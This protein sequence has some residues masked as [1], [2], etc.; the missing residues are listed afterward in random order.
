VSRGLVAERAPL[1]ERWGVLASAVA[2][3]SFLPFAAGVL[4]GRCFYYRDLV[5]AFF[6]LRRFGIEGLLHGEMRFWNAYVHEGEPLS[7]PAISY[8]LDLLQ[9]LVP[10]ERGFS[11]LLALHVPV[12]AVAFL[13]L[14]RRLGLSPLAAAGAALVYSLGGF[15]LSCLN[16]YV[17][18]LAAAWAP[19]VVVGV[20][21]AAE[22]GA[23]RTA[24]GAL[25]TALAISTLGM[26]I[27]LQALLVGLVLAWRPREPGRVV[28][29]AGM[30]AL[31]C[32]L[33]APL[34]L[35]LR[36]VVPQGGRAG[37]MPVDVVLAYSVHPLSLLQVVVQR[38]FGD[39]S[40]LPGSWWGQNFFPS[41]YPYFQSLYLG[42]TV[43]GVALV[44]ATRPS[45]W[46][47]R[48]IALA[49]L[50]LVIALGYWGGLGP[51]VALHPALRMLRFP[52]KAFF[53]V[54]VAV[55]LFAGA[56]L[57]ALLSG[58]EGA[59]RR[60]AV[61]ASSAGA[62]LVLALL[63]PVALPGAY[64]WFLEGF[65]PPGRPWPAMAETGALVLR[66]AARG[67]A[68]ALVAGLV[69]AAVARSRASAVFGTLATLGLVAGD[70]LSA[71]A[72]VN[73]MV[74]P[75]FYQL[76]PDVAAALPRLRSEG[77]AFTCEPHDSLTFAAAIAERTR[78]RRPLD[79]WS[80]GVLVETLYP[81]TNVPAAVPTAYGVDHTRFYSPSR[82][83]TRGEADCHPFPAIRDRL[84][85][86]GV[87]RVLSLDPLDDP[88]LA[89]QGEIRPPALDPLVLHVYA[90]TGALPLRSVASAVRTAAD[91]ES[92]EARA[93]LPFLQSGGT[94]LEDAGPEV[95]GV[96]G[97]LQTLEE[98]PG[99]VRLDVS[100]AGPTAVVVRDTFAPGWTARVNG[101][102]APISRAD[103]RHLAVR[104]PAGR[105]EVSLR[106]VPPH[107]RPGLL[108][109]A[110]SA[111]VVAAGLQ[112]RRVAS[113]S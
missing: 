22:G 16:L 89:L 3:L 18:L 91:A 97:E 85:R 20:L 80:Y 106:Y 79:P 47:W 104:V 70:L 12:A 29:A 72:G 4:L 48:M 68:F 81:N 39:L 105:S 11:L 84:R 53:T 99:K 38:F 98:S 109:A 66:D 61:I 111:V 59:W 102:P 45:A 46:R 83:F 42:A 24:E 86:A 2:V 87:A 23:R 14:G 73:S 27:V 30:L 108:L 9:L 17:Y 101:E 41:G 51:V 100:A 31:A 65:L 13:C 49:G 90:L 113:G 15:T 55:S 58:V 35:F 64:R 112:R 93:D 63:L 44:G 60:F 74:T 40:D 88:A 25:L 8:P 33:T 82:V 103:G 69:A 5:V 57:Q 56:G 7:M 71:G 37:G 26:E 77:R 43:L 94:V 21:H 110:A 1:T 19:V 6:P 95:A 28:R 92:V 50:A 96:R 75:A 54:H 76:T 32:G 78:D 52:V 67:G 62:L 10:D 107:L 34:L 36:D